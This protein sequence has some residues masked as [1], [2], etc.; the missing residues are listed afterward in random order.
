MHRFQF[1]QYFS[2][3]KILDIG[4]ASADGWLYPIPIYNITTPPSLNINNMIFVDCDEWKN[5]YK[6]PFIRCITEKLPLRN[7][8]FDTVVLGDILEHVEDSNIVLQEA[9]RV[10]KDRIIITVPNEWEYL[11]K[12]PKTFADNT[13]KEYIENGGNLIDLDLQQTINHVSGKC[14]DALNNKDFI[15]IHHVRF[16]NEKT[17]KEL[18]EKNF[19]DWNYNIYNLKYSLYN[20]VH[21]AAIIWKR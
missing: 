4:C 11:L 16:Y 13:I 20:Y 2:Y 14:I 9:K 21:L 7:K 12:N 6:I 8:L 1:H 17:L 19:N 3:G 15:H 10:C 18:I 5:I